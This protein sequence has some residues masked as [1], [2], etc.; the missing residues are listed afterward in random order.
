MKH[1]IK[2]HVFKIALI[3]LIPTIGLLIWLGF[4]TNQ[5][6]H[7]TPLADTAPAT[8]PDFPR[9]GMWWPDPAEQSYNDIARYDWVSLFPHQEQYVAPIKAVN[10]D[11]IL[12][13]ST[14]ACEL[15]F[16]PEGT[17][18]D[19]AEVLAIPPE[20]FLTQVGSTLTQAVN[21][22]TTTL[23]VAATTA[24]D[25]TDIFPLFVVSDTVL[26]EGE[27][28]FVE[29]VDAATNS[30]TV[31]RG[32]VRPAAAHTAGTRIA[33]HISF[34]P[35]S[36]LLNLST[37]SP[38]AVVSA[39]VGAE[40]WATYNARVG[41][42][43]L[44]NP[45][46]D[47]LLI[48]RS[49][50]NESW[51]IGSSTAR[52]I[53]PDQSNTLLTDYSGFDAAW[54]AGLRQYES[55]LRQAVGNDKILFANWGKDNFDLLNG[56]NYES[57]PLEDGRAYTTGWNQVV[58]GNLPDVGSYAAW[59]QQGQQPNLT[60]IETYEDDG[61]PSATGDG[62]YANPCDDP[63]FV[64]NYRKMRFGLTTALL[65]DGYFSYEI[66]T[67]GHG[68][69]CLLWFDE[70]DNVGAG[71]GYL[72]QPLGPAYRVSSTA[73][74]VN[75]LSGNDFEAQSDLDQWDF[76][77]DGSAG[78]TGS[79]VLDHTTAGNGATSARI[80]V[81]Q[82]QGTNWQVAFSF[83]PFEVI[84][85]TE[86]TLSFWAKADQLRPIST[87]AQQPVDPWQD[88][89]GF[90]DVTVSAEWQH[91]VQTATATGNDTQAGLYFGLG[92]TTGTIWL[93]DVRL[94]TGSRDVWRRDY[95]G[96][97]ALTNATATQ[98]TLE[99]NETLQK[100]AGTQDPTVNDGSS[101]TQ[102]TLPAH[103]GIVLLRTNAPTAITLTQ[104]TST[105]WLPFVVLP[106][107]GVL[108]VWMG[109]I[110]PKLSHKDSTEK[111]RIS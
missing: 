84:S 66:N 42:N 5:P 20:W 24:S 29:A 7:A 22:T 108:L 13:N 52:T 94:Q 51:L 102:V 99:L 12:L 67:N 35:G 90:G 49:D 2:T 111:T 58:F 9:L 95:T 103:D 53:D 17:A 27:T 107:L 16:D 1:L 33:A 104:R 40:R 47:G 100:I 77:A 72:G 54:N 91:F 85:G 31:Q 105:G 87:W 23:H 78:Y 15:G 48:D 69:L 83:A 38:T 6:I 50:G 59:M 14:N 61:G 60:M 3:F 82:A 76:W 37:L 45:D 56:N 30:L 10:P 68:A 25:G 81:T 93:D 96:G 101:V 18:E 26:I 109:W 32:Y 4:I 71:R 34:W 80:D 55:D 70:Y 44:K 89:L 75:M 19:N 36:W 8:A 79:V 41:I 73:L 63:N 21:A 57:F 64:P 46:W 39:T 65:N 74:G 97:V 106:V 110:R 11:I 28:V 88:Y 98:Q 43:L 86:Y 92:Q 62:S